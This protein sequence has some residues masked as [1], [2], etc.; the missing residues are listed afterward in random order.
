[1]KAGIVVAIA[2]VLAAPAMFGEKPNGSAPSQGASLEIG[3][4]V[5]A[6][7]GTANGIEL[8]IHGAGAKKQVA[9]KALEGRQIVRLV[10]TSSQAR[11]SGTKGIF[12]GYIGLG[13]EVLS[14]DG[15]LLEYRMA[16]CRNWRAVLQG[17]SP[18]TGFD[19]SPVLITRPVDH[20]FDVIGVGLPGGD[21]LMLTLQDLTRKGDSPP[22]EIETHTFVDH[23]P[24][25]MFVVVQH[26]ASSSME[27]RP[28]KAQ[29]AKQEK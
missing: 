5:W 13:I 6:F 10:A 28:I 8:S 18:S 9:L 22:D 17:E 23:C 16:F 11:G 24:S 27:L 15:M 21:S 26:Y 12:R 19:C 29:E 14:E 25:P 4:A 1:M 7:R 20:P 2:G 3:D